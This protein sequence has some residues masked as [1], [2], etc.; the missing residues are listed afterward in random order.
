MMMRTTLTLDEDVAIQ[1]QHEMRRT[2]KT[3]KQTV[4]DAVRTGLAS[5]HAVASLPA[6]EVRA[7]PMGVVQGLDY[8]NVTDLLEVAEGPAHR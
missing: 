5:R 7:R 3:F 6:F 1:L 2:G 4:N 8:S